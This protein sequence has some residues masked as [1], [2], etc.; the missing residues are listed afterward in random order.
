MSLT[1]PSYCR[2]ALRLA[3]GK[4]LNVFYVGKTSSGDVTVTRVALKMPPIFESSFVRRQFVGCRSRVSHDNRASTINGTS[5][6][7]SIAT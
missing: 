4:Q 2:R 7:N 3:P 1:L 5:P 6:F